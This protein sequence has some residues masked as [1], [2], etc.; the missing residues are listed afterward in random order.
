MPAGDQPP[1]DPGPL[2]LSV[3]QRLRDLSKRFGKRDLAAAEPQRD[4]AFWGGVDVGGSE[5]HDPGNTSPPTG[6]S[7]A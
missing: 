4:L 3:A 7:N 6:C 2:K 5:R 1:V